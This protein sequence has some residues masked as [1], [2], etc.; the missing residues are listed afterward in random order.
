MFSAWRHRRSTAQQR[1]HR[2]ALEL[3]PAAEAP[4]VGVARSTIVRI[5]SADG[6]GGGRAGVRGAAN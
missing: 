5:S 4:L 2:I 3:D 1:R 6:S